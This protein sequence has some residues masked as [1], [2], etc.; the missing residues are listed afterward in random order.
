MKVM[1]NIRLYIDDEP[2]PE[3]MGTNRFLKHSHF[4]RIGKFSQ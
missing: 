3:N 4:E 2:R 1:H